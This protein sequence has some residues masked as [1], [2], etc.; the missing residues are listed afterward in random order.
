MIQGSFQT[1]N[2]ATDLYLD[3]RVRWSSALQCRQVNVVPQPQEATEVFNTQTWC[4]L[5]CVTAQCPMQMHDSGT[6]ETRPEEKTLGLYFNLSCDTSSSA[7]CVHEL[8]PGCPEQV[9]GVWEQA[10][11]TINPEVVF[12]E[13]NSL[14]L[15]FVYKHFIIICVCMFMKCL[16]STHRQYNRTNRFGALKILAWEYLYTHIAFV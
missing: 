15:A 16:D 8:T 4:R 10:L 12:L 11:P 2:R 13:H 1:V 6:E 3:G 9:S 5:C 7:L 14:S